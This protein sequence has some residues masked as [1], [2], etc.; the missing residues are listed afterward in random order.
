LTLNHLT[1]LI[2][3]FLLGHGL[4]FAQ[5]QV[6]PNAHSHNDYEHAG[7][8]K[9]AWQN[10]FTSAEVDVHLYKGELRVAHSIATDQSPNLQQL[11]LIP[12]D[13]LIKA[14]NGFIYGGNQ[15]PFLLMIDLKTN[16]EQTYEALKL[17]LGK[18]EKLVCAQQACPVKIVLSG[19]RPLKTMITEG[20]KGIGIDGRPDDLGKQYSVEL[21]PVI[22]DTFKNWSAWNG[23]QPIEV[24]D[25]QRIK[26]LAHRVHAEGKKL[27]LWAIPDNEVAWS[28][29]LDAGVDLINTD[30]LPELNAYLKSKGL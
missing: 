11:Y 23:K 7:P 25:L 1:L 4:T 9:E 28:A 15:Q 27:R 17:V 3:L 20:Y 10:G 19:Q 22:S 14:N 6:H 8:L 24:Q 16:G 13:S 30:H 12:L 21:M 29:L 2:G 26:A 18:H 5:L